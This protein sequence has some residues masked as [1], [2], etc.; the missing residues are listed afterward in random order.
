MEAATSILKWN[1]C[2]ENTARVS[3][4][5]KSLV[6]H[7]NS[8]LP[9][10]IDREKLWRNFHT[11]R[12][13]KDHL[14]LWN[15]FL[16]ESVKSVKKGSPIFLQYVT[17]HIFKQLIKK[18]F[19][20]PTTV[21]QEPTDR[22]LHLSYEEKNAIRYAAGYIP[23]NLL[24][25]LKRSARPN[26]RSLTM[27]LLDVIEEDCMGNDESQDWV[28]LINRGGLKYINNDMFSFMSAME[29]V[30]KA[31][32]K[33]KEKPRDIRSEMIKL[34]GDSDTV[35]KEWS[36]VAAEWEPEESEVIFGMVTDLWVTMRGFSYASE[37]MEKWKQETK[38]SVQKSQ[39]LRKKLNKN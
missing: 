35:R 26:K 14:I 15:D 7:L 11:F 10:Q 34:I 29:L 6:C 20:A 37:W 13:S 23:R 18:Q 25:K 39:A 22:N 38:K 16:K 27:C 19:P 9:A 21:H 36:E 5:S 28:K 17:N 32:L 31:F 1:E 3:C 12:I 24:S 33:G 30:V 8:C 4:F 2:A